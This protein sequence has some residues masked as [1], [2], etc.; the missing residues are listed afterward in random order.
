MGTDEADYVAY[1]DRTEQGWAQILD[2]LDTTL[3]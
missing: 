1:K 2:A 3:R